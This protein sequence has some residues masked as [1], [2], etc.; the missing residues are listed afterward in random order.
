MSIEEREIE[1]INKYLGEEAKKLATGQVMKQVK[2][3]FDDLYGVG[4]RLQEAIKPYRPLLEEGKE[5]E[6][7]MVVGGILFGNSKIPERGTS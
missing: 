2:D 3:G 6:Y 7:L 4:K 1:V 5:T